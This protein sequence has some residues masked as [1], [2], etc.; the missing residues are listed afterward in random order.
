ML[1]GLLAL[2][3]LIIIGL[4]WYAWTLHKAVEQQQQK[5]L[6]EEAVAA[7]QLRNHQLELMQDIRFVARA[8]ISDQ[9][10]I[11][12]GV[13]RLQYLISGLDPNAWQRPELDTLRTHYDAT[14]GMPILDAYQALSKKAQF[15]LDRERWQLES[16]H[17]E[18]LMQELHWLVKFEF[19]EVTLLQ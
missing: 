1:Y 6:E 7:Q 9:C 16:D 19:P 17:K 14:S 8:M 2:G 13:L 18:A 4:S 10:E 5:R 11:T 3:I 12:E 15:K